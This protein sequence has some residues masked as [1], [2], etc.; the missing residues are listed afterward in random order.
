MRHLLINV[1][2][3]KIERQPWFQPPI[4]LN[5]S[6]EE[7]LISVV[8]RCANCAFAK[9]WL[10]ITQK[11]IEIRIFVVASL[12]LHK[13]LRRNYVAPVD[14]KLER[15]PAEVVSRLVDDLITVLDG[16]LWRVRVWPNG[17]TEIVEIDIRKLVQP[18]IANVRHRKSL[19]VP[20]VCQTSF[21]RELGSEV[22]DQRVRKKPAIS[23]N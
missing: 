13:R 2:Q 23:W 14:A 11:Q 1:V 6:V 16:E 8:G 3:S 18:G 21:I 12:A 5:K 17:K 19:N 22:M 15:V 4:V 7:M 9:A 20:P 10:N